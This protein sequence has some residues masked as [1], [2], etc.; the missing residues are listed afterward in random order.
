MEGFLNRITF[1]KKGSHLELAYSLST[2][3][4]IMAL[5]RFIAREGRTLTIYCDNATNFKGMNKELKVEMNKTNYE[6]IEKF[7]TQK[8][9]EWN[10]KD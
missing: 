10:R 5:K 6:E 3:S 1:D 7:S 2:D 9:I 4:A 8:D